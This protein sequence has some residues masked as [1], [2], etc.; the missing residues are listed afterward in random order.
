[1]LAYFIHRR[2]KGQSSK[3]D[4]IIRCLSDAT[5]GVNFDDS[6]EEALELQRYIEGE[7][8]LVLSTSGGTEV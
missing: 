3:Q 2:V 7:E 5:A 8:V 4:T 6:K 1:M